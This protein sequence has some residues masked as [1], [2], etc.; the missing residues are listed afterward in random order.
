MLTPQIIIFFSIV[1]YF[2][3]LPDLSVFILSNMWIVTVSEV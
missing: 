2:I 1:L 3:L